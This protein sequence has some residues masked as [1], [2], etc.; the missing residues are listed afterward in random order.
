MI[1]LIDDKKLRQNDFGWG[2]EKFTQYAPYIIPL[3]SIEDVVQIGDDLYNEKNIILYHESFLD[4]TTDSK[5]AIGQR[6]KLQSIAEAKVNLSIAF[7]SG[8]QGSRSLNGNIAYIPVSTLYQNLEILVNEY[9]KGTC[10]LEHLLYGQ[11][12]RI[13]EE[14]NTKL[15]QANRDIES[16]YAKIGGNNLFIRPTNNFIQ[17][18]IR[19]AIEGKLFNDVSDEKFSEKINEWLNEIEYDNIFLPLCFGPTLS[20][21]NGLRLATHIRCTPTKNQLKRIYIYGFVGL[22]YLV[23]HEYFNILKTK[24][25]ELVSYSKKAFESVANKNIE[26]LKLL[27]LSSEIKKLK[28]DPPLNYDDSHSIANEW[29]IHQWAKIIGCDT[30]DELLNIYNKVCNNIYFKYLKT[31]NPLSDIDRISPERLKIKYEGNPKILLI[32]DEAEKGWYEIFCTILNDINGISFEHLDLEL[33]LKTEDE[34]IKISIDNIIENDIDLVILDF[35][36]HPNDFNYRDASEITSL[37]LLKK[38]KKELNQ[39]IQVIIFS[40]TNKASNLQL[41]QKLSSD[42]FIIKEAPDNGFNQ[43]L[44][45]Q[46]IYD[47]K[48][49]IE[50]CLEK[51]FLKDLFFQ[52]GPIEKLVALESIKKP[53]RY[54]LS[55]QQ[56]TIQNINQKIQIFKQLLYTFTSNLEWPFSML[57]LIIEE[58][59]ND[60]Y[61]DDDLDHIVQI[62]FFNT[63]KCN[64]VSSNVRMLSIKPI[65]KKSEYINESYIIPQDE[66]IYYNKSANRD[67]FN[68]RLTCILH[69]KFKLPLGDEIYKFYSLYNTRSRSVM[70]AGQEKIEPSLLKSGLELLKILVQ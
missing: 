63:V 44:L 48:N 56:P 17:N 35:R 29:A 55:I 32:D 33:T 62:D 68:F 20:D 2:N 10:K 45:I 1:Y 5:K 13:E 46:S 43:K 41:M 6:M 19:G 39:G 28:L 31:I 47:L 50:N 25:V 24:N 4:F 70:H 26:S 36:L 11:N 30:T 22:D 49:T 57:I 54:S 16:E 52:L 8:S 12:P 59:V 51:C 58:I 34:I 40:A 18:A 7:F 27:E 3:Y 61:I 67:P 53:S 38:I 21:Y 42:G 69:F 9:V 15:N 37:R 60:I 66:L 65:S 14:L 23:E 64:Y